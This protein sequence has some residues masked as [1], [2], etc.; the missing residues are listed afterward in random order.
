MRGKPS[1]GALA[2]AGQIDYGGPGQGSDKS[3]AND[4]GGR[5]GAAAGDALGVFGR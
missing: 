4:D 5:P 1:G 3:K 2:A